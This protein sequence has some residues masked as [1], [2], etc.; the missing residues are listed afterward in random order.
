MFTHVCIKPN[1]GKTYSSPDIDPYYCSS[2]DKERKLVAQEI[3][4][5]LAGR[6]SKKQVKS[7]LQMYDEISKARG[8]KFINVRDLGITF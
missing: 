1:C 6:V 4:K 3:D 2:C 8:S 5:K 7:E